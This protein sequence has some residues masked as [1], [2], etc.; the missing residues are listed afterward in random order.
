M[1]V[2]TVDDIFRRQFATTMKLHAL[3]DLESVLG[4]VVVDAP[5][6]GQF[7]VQAHVVPDLDESVIHG[8]GPYIVDSRRTENRIQRIVRPVQV[9][10]EHHGPATGR[11]RRQRT[12]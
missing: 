12:G 1:A 6:F 7:R 8:V 4:R 10:R 3:A 2:H 9:G 5:L 11:A